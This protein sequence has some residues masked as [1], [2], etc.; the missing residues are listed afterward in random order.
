MR[1]GASSGREGRR[2]RNADE[3]AVFQRKVT[4]RR[5][6][7]GAF[8]VIDVARRRRASPRNQFIYLEHLTDFRAGVYCHYLTI[9]VNDWHL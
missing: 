6:H 4:F 8:L 7:V 1:L 5:G 9:F 3:V 2:R